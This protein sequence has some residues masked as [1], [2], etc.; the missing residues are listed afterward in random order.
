MASVSFDLVYSGICGPT[1]CHL[2]LVIVI[3]LVSLMIIHV[4]LKFILCVCVQIF[5]NIVYTQFNKRIKVFQSDSARE[6]HS[7]SMQN[8]FKSHDTLSL[9][10]SQQ[11]SP[12]THE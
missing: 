3:K 9:S 6:Y 11:L 2:C 1:L 7:S 10:L 12:H 4:M 8:I 5:T